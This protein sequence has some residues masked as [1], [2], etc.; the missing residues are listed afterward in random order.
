MGQ[1]AALPELLTARARCEGR[2]GV[3]AAARL[4]LPRVHQLAPSFPFAALLE[5]FAT[6]E[7]ESEATAAVEPIIDEV[8]EA[9][10]RE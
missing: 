3:E 5:E 1:L 2:Q 4:I 9:A 6:P 7:E 8:K 10:K